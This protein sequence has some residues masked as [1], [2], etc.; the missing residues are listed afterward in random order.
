MKNDTSIFDIIRF[1]LNKLKILFWILLNENE[2]GIRVYDKIESSN[3]HIKLTQRESFSKAI[4]TLSIEKSLNL[5]SKIYSLNPFQHGD[6]TLHERGRLE[7]SNFEFD[8]RHPMILLSK[9]HL[10]NISHCS[11]VN[12]GDFCMF[13]SY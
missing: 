10:T 4:Q 11:K 1:V 6:N 13:K 9:H 3:N 7:R 12:I 8:K 2:E 5:R